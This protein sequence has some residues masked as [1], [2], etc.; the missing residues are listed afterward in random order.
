LT[1]TVDNKKITDKAMN[2]LSKLLKLQSIKIQRFSSV[3]P[4]I[5][6]SGLIDVINNFPQINSILFN[7]RPNISHKTIDA[8]IALA[9]RKT[10]IQFKHQFYVYYTSTNGIVLNKI[11]SNKEGNSKLNRRFA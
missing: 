3:L 1:I 9:L 5:T 11:N 4:L 7:S 6:D 10:R 8:L 2:S